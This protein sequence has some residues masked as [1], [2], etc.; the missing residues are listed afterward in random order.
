MGIF[1]PLECVYSMGME[2]WVTPGSICFP[3]WVFVKLDQK[4]LIVSN[5]ILAQVKYIL[6][7]CLR[8]QILVNSKNI[9]FDIKKN[10]LRK[11]NHK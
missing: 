6:N 3:C 8:K 11:Y 4:K 10:K 9:Y 7:S 2:L 5:S 1:V